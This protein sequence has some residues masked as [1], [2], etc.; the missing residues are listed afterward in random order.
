MSTPERVGPF[1]RERLVT[2]GRTVGPL[3]LIYG[4]GVTIA[5]SATFTVAGSI[6]ILLMCVAGLI[7]SY[8]GAR[9]R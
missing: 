1:D 9:D 4:V 7:W 6:V 8:L 5:N 2:I 3:A